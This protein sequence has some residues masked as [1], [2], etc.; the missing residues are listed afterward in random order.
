MYVLF[1]PQ[2]I[3]YFSQQV[4]DEDESNVKPVF[5]HNGVTFAYVR[6]NN[7]YC[8]SLHAN[9]S[10]DFSHNS[11]DDKDNALTFYLVT[12]E[13]C[14]IF[15]SM[16]LYVNSRGVPSPWVIGPRALGPSS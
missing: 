15:L 9:G 16:C 14:S 13:E 10:K 6:Q 11:E 3:E 7:V 5:E 8:V 2:V 4:I 12:H 1:H